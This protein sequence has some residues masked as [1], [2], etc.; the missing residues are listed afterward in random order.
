M[1]VRVNRVEGVGAMGKKVEEKRRERT[2]D[3]FLEEGKRGEREREVEGGGGGRE[4]G[5]G[6]ETA[7]ESEHV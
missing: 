6:K 2:R 4:K 1:N 3:K 7:H 5:R